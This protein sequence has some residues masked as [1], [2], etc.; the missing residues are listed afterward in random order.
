MKLFGRMI[1][2]FRYQITKLLYLFV[3][4]LIEK[5]GMKNKTV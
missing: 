4:K 2:I 5:T 1:L 3:K